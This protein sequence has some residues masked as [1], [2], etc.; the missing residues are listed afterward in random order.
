MEQDIN[1]MF[2]LNQ[3]KSG[4]DRKNQIVWREEISPFTTMGEEIS[5]FTTNTK[6]RDLSIYNYIRIEIYT[7]NHFQK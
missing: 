4:G 3:F 1:A 6:R 7:H 5:L 2:L